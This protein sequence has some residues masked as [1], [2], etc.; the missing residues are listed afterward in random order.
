MLQVVG[1]ALIRRQNSHTRLNVFMDLDVLR[2]LRMAISRRLV[3][4][5]DGLASTK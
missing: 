1:L 4:V 2:E 5:L 3:L